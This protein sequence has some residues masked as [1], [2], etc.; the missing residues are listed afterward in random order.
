[1]SKPRHELMKEFAQKMSDLYDMAEGLRDRADGKDK[2]IFNKTRGALYNLRDEATDQYW[3][4]KPE[5]K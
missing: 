4:W 2:D 5:E 1:M 3:R